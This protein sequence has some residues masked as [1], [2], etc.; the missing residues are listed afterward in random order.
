MLKALFSEEFGRFEDKIGNEFRVQRDEIFVCSKNGYVPDD[1][2]N[3][4]PASLLIS[5]LVEEGHI[6][7]EDV[8]GG[9]HCIHPAFLQHQLSS[10]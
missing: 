10:S 3:G 1:A 4:I 5:Q 8:A 6:S 9:I 2:D 7:A